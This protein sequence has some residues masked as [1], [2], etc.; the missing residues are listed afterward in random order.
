MCQLRSELHT[1]DQSSAQDDFRTT[2]E[3]LHDYNV[4]EWRHV[5]PRTEAETFQQS[6]T[7]CLK[8]KKVLAANNSCR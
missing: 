6:S 4:M 1:R 3:A 7:V 8:I 5:K 2:T